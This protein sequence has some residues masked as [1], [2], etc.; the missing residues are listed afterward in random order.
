MLRRLLFANCVVAMVLVYNQGQGLL[1]M[2]AVLTA[3]TN[4]IS[5][6]LLCLF[7]CG[8]EGSCKATPYPNQVVV[9]SLL[10]RITAIIGV[11]LSGYVLLL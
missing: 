4:L 11:L 7:T 2:F 5:S 10:N 9:M 1:F 8:G 6:Q 3:V